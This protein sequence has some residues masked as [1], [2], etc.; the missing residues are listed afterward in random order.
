VEEI[1]DML[2]IQLNMLMSKEKTL[3]IG[4]KVEKG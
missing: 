4:E 3:K 2:E 1:K